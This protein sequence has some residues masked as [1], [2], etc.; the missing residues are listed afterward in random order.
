MASGNAEVGVPRSGR[1]EE[2]TYIVIS[3]S[4]RGHFLTPR[5]VGEIVE[6]RSEV[7]PAFVIKILHIATAVLCLCLRKRLCPGSDVLGVEI[8]LDNSVLTFLCGDEHDT[9]RG[10]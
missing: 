5:V 8:N 6:F 4:A 2:V 9:V 1:S 7:G 3:L 10:A